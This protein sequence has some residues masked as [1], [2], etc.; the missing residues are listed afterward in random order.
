MSKC[1]SGAFRLKFLEWDPAKVTAL[2]EM[3]M[4]LLIE[5]TYHVLSLSDVLLCA[6]SCWRPVTLSY[7]PYRGDI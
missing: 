1:L 7:H 2:E 5:A 4:F 3:G 6:L